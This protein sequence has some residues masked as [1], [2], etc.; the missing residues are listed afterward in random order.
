MTNIRA[1]FKIIKIKKKFIMVIA[2]M[3]ATSNLCPQDIAF[4]LM[5]WF[6]IE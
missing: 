2:N 1:S 4:F 6:V 5:A 3:P